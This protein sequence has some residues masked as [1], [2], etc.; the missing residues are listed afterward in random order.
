M[1]Q[2][3]LDLIKAHSKVFKLKIGELIRFETETSHYYWLDGAYRPG[4][5]SI[6]QE[7]SPTHYGLKRFWQ[8]NTKEEA[9]TIF[10][11]A[12]DFGSKMHDAF[13]RLLLG[14]ELDVL[15][16]YPTEREKK[17]LVSFVDWFSYYK[18]ASFESEQSLASAKYQYAGTLDFV[19]T[20]NGERW[21]IDFKTSNAIHMSHQLQVL[22]YKQAYEES[23]GVKID[24]CAIL[25]LGTLHKGAGAVKEG[26]LK[27][28]GKAWEFKEVKDYSIDDFMNIYR[29]YLSLHGGKIP[30][31]SEIAVYP[32]KLKLLEEV[33]V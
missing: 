2:T 15:T 11:T 24:R 1:D 3:K 20:I 29:V 9:D 14:E 4:V 30:E 27:E 33:H 7:A 22:A 18:P 28:I 10:E 32:E 21:L 6:L 12:G 23:Y 8:D 13:A 25:R 5:S 26:T 17:T 31:P 19:G 16:G